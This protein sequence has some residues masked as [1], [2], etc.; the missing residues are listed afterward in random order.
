MVM[1]V[2]MAVVQMREVVVLLVAVVAVA[3]VAPLGPLNLLGPL[4]P[5]F[6]MQTYQHKICHLRKWYN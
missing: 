2:A 5:H 3:V 1:V 6:L 4:D